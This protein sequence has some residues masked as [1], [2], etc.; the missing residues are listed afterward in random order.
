MSEF[1]QKEPTV[2]PETPVE[3][4]GKLDK[5]KAFA[6]QHRIA[7]IALSVAVIGSFTFGYMIGHRQG[8]T[9]VGFAADAEQLGEV[10]Q[11]QKAELENVSKRFNETVQ[12]RDVAVSNANKF[13]QSYNDARATTSQVEGLN[14]MYRD[15]LRNRG[16]VSLTVQN[17]AVKPLPDN[18]FEYVI[19]LVQVSETNQKASGTV[20]VRLVGDD[21]VL[22]VP[23]EDNS[24]NFDNYERL[25]GRWTMP[26]GF[27][28]K[29]IEVRLNGATPVAKRFS[30]QK[31]NETTLESMLLADIPQVKADTK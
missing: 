28:P 20:D 15:L 17:I 22:S 8:L 29:Y 14:A 18:A 7:L 13:Y 1:E 12:E 9:A 21:D 16:G 3:G 2:T 11:K 26:K 25:T 19:D 31:G 24:F 30:W 6:K 10:V 23:L 5:A 27:T 4:E